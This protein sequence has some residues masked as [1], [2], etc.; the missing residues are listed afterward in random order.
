MKCEEVRKR[1]QQINVELEKISLMELKFPKVISTEGKS[2]QMLL[3]PEYRKLH[4][5]YCFPDDEELE[6]RNAL[7]KGF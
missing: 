6:L 4:G 7:N 5:K 2:D 3:H 1:M